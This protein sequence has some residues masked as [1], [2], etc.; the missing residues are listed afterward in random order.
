MSGETKVQ[1]PICGRMVRLVDKSGVAVIWTHPSAE[2][3]SVSRRVWCRASR[4]SLEAAAG[5][6]HASDCPHWAGESCRCH[7]GQLA[8]KGE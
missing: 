4:L 6:P 1:C 2:P 5:V 3:F 7:A 8:V